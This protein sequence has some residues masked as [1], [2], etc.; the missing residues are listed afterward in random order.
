VRDAV[1]SLA[2]NAHL[3]GMAV[4]LYSAPVG[5]ANRRFDNANGYGQMVSQGSIRLTGNQFGGSPLARATLENCS[6]RGGGRGKCEATGID[7]R[8]TAK[9]LSCAARAHVPKPTRH[10]ACLHVSRAMR[11]A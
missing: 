4:V 7:V 11:A 6:A 9:A 1:D 2:D 10:A 3:N 8:L 5:R